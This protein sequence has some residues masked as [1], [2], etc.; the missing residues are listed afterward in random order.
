M[1]RHVDLK[2]IDV[3]GE[4]LFSLSDPTGIVE[5]VLLLQPSAAY[6]VMHLD[7]DH[8]IA[9]IHAKVEAQFNGDLLPENTISNLITQL[10][11]YGFLESTTYE[12]KYQ[13]VVL[14]F[15]DSPVRASSMAGKSYPDNPEELRAFLDEQFLRDSAIGE[16][17]PEPSH[18]TP[19][20][21]G[22]IVPHI[23]LQRGGHSYSHGYHALA[24]AGKPDTIIIFGVAHAAQP[25]PF[26][27][28]R[29]DFET[30]LGTLSTDTALVDRLASKC[31]W[32]PFEFELTHRT[33]HSIEFQ[34]LMLS[35]IYG[36]TVKIVP[37]LASYFGEDTAFLSEGQNGPLHAFLNECRTI[38]RESKGKANVIGGVD[39]A[40]VG[41]CFGDDFDIDDD[42]IA[43]VEDRDREDLAHVERLDPEG[44]FRSVM[45]D[46]NL[47]KVCGLN[48]IYATAYTLQDTVSHAEML[49]Y[50]YAH[51]PSDGIVSFVSMALR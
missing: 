26:I 5:E 51:D 4:Q 18:D 50:D 38:V 3:E 49:H 33:E 48:A 30:P 42:V 43:N 20:L 40:H 35:Y 8:D 47:R 41:R 21:P 22:L 13:S 12:A 27:L 24:S 6:I 19:P 37:I 44:F 46:R 11:E 45:R 23:D 25:V 2:P 7:G 1:L 16:M 9:E 34:T 31:T 39:M 36:P 28:T 10:D 17:C 14:G 32:D 15:L 29:K